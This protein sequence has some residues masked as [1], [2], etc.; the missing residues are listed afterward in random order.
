LSKD[1]VL[2]LTAQT[3]HFLGYVDVLR[4]FIVKC[5]SRDLHANAEHHLDINNGLTQGSIEN[6]Q[7]TFPAFFDLFNIVLVGH[8]LVEMDLV[9]QEFVVS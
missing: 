1:T 3:Y 8:N 2:A 7:V 4:K 5:L 6:S 9:V